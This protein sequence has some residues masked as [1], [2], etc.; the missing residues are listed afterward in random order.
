MLF[1][2]FSIKS[3]NMGTNMATVTNSNSQYH[4]RL[5]TFEGVKMLGSNFTFCNTTTSRHSS[6]LF[7][8][9]YKLASMIN[10]MFPFTRDEGSP[11][12]LFLLIYQS[13]ITQML[14]I[15]AY[16]KLLLISTAVS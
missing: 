12:F 11:S 9:P 1:I 7:S 13:G 6:A 3:F 15:S 4:V 10:Y 5:V 16:F 8:V 14:V 2:F